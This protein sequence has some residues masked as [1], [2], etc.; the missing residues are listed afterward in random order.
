M[1]KIKCFM[2]M[3]AVALFGFICTSFTTEEK[4]RIV[5]DGGTGPYK[6]IMKED[7]SLK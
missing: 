6:A 2:S 5:E 3:V 4:S 1:R 7:A